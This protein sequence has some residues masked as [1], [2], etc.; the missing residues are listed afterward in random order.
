MNKLSFINEKNEIQFYSYKPSLIDIYYPC[1]EKD[2]VPH[3]FSRLIHRFRMVREIVKSHYQVVY[4][5]K[6]NKV[7]GHLVVGRG[8]SR[9]EMST[10]KDIVIGPIWV[11]PKQ[12]SFGYASQG[13][14]FVL[15]DMD[16]DYE[17]AYEYIEKDNTPSIRT[18]EKNGFD[19]VG[20]CNEYGLFKMI[21]PCKGGHLNVYR[22]KKNSVKT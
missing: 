14:K 8:G 2:E 22:I 21:R 15:N 9:I 13:I 18:V 19:F 12:R 20:E 4:M 11:V 5:I 10:P 16:I 7:I 3:Y 6:D 1:Y 17:Y